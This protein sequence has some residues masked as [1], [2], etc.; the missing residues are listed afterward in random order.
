MFH[1]KPFLTNPSEPVGARLLS[2]V[3]LLQPKGLH[4]RNDASC[5]V[6]LE[7]ANATMELI[8]PLRGI[9]RQ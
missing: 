2:T 8:A 4:A 7:P 9:V 5:G 1:N 3:L 6:T